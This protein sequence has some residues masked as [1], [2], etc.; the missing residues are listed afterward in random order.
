MVI[1]YSDDDYNTILQSMKDF[2]LDET[3][4]NTI[5][6]LAKQVGNPEYVKTPQFV[7]RKP[8]RYSD[9]W[10]SIRNFKTTEIKKSEGIDASIDTIRKNL[11]KM[12]KKTYDKLIGKIFDEINSIC[13]EKGFSKDDEGLVNDEDI[14]KLGSTMFSIACGSA[15]LSDMYADMYV[16]LMDEYSFMKT[17]FKNNFKEFSK[18]FHSIDYC[19]P[20]EDYDKFCENNKTNERRRSISLFYVN[21]M[22]KKVICVNDILD[23]IIQLH[24][25]MDEQIDTEDKSSIVDELSEILF[26]MIPPVR[27]HVEEIH[28]TKWDQIIRHVT[29]ISQM[30]HKCRVSITNKSIFKHMDILDTLKKEETSV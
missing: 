1:Q 19:S 9:D 13:S 22:I 4:V 15:F 23:I 24:T 10:E 30:K 3:V 11:N 29:D 14:V 18:L 2:S 5:I 8:R 16:K 21:L 26:K 27:P 12:T 6:D 17:I 25:Y 7:K 20:N 28:N